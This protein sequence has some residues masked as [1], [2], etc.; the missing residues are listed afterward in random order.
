MLAIN[1]YFYLSVGLWSFWC[2]EILLYT[3]PGWSSD[4]GEVRGATKLWALQTTTR[5]EEEEE[6]LTPVSNRLYQLLVRG[7][8]SCSCK[9]HGV[10]GILNF[11]VELCE[12][13]CKHTWQE[14]IFSVW[15]LWSSNSPY[16]FVK[17]LGWEAWRNSHLD[18]VSCRQFAFQDRLMMTA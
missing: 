5:P 12:T 8:T 13:C 17:P 1:C 15:N 3:S 7:R 10:R 14:L 16:M 11:E 6:A 18:T 4:L 2:L 9:M